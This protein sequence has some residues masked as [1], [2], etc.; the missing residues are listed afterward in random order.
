MRPYHPE[1]MSRAH[2][3]LSA[4]CRVK[5][6]MYRQLGTKSRRNTEVRSELGWLRVCCSDILLPSYRY[7]DPLCYW[8]H[9]QEID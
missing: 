6:T 7:L 8:T 5:W 9:T 3:W 1:P 2:P 4:E